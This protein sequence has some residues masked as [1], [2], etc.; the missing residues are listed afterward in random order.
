MIE[1]IPLEL[2]FFSTALVLLYFLNPAQEHHS[3]CIINRLGFDFCPGCGLGRSIHYLMH[4]EFG[5]SFQIHPLGFFGFFVIIYRIY[6]LII[7]IVNNKH[8]KIYDQR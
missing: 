5:K 3:L 4:G 1:K 2:L 7:K 8:I 6:S